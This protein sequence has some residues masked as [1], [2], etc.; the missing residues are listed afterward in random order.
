MNYEEIK[1]YINIGYEEVFGEEKS[2]LRITEHY[3]DK[4]ICDGCGIRTGNYNTL[5]Y[6]TKDK[7]KKPMQFLFC[8][9]CYYK[10]FREDRLQ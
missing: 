8:T 1:E 9:D 7:F 4:Y 6:N 10:K 2:I 3:K 5:I